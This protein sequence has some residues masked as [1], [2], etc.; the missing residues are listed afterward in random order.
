M[1]IKKI[2]ADLQKLPDGKQTITITATITIIAE[3]GDKS[4]IDTATFKF[5]HIKDSGTPVELSVHNL[6]LSA[7]YTGSQ[8]FNSNTGT[9]VEIDT[10]M[11]ESDPLARFDD[12]QNHELKS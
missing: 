10:E 11:R 6:D 4:Y 7:S 9:A 12:E 2:I 3:N 1:I 5:H 8:R